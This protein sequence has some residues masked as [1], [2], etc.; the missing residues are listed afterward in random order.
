MNEF[1]YTITSTDQNDYATIRTNLIGP[2]TELTEFI[3]T[4][5]TTT[6]AFNVLEYTD[7][8]IYSVVDDIYFKKYMTEFMEMGMDKVQDFLNECF[9]EALVQGVS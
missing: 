3:I 6:C 1:N 5:L 9:G 8:I 4:N 2:R 7:Y